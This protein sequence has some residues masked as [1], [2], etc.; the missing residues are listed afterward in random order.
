MDKLS[1]TTIEVITKNIKVFC[2]LCKTFEENQLMLVEGDDISCLFC[3]HCNFT[4]NISIVSDL[5][6]FK[7]RTEEEWIR[8]FKSYI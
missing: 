1:K 3:P 8:L 2:P 4:I 6:A 7:Q 5:W